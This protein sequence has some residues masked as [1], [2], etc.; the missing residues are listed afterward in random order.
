MNISVHYPITSNKDITNMYKFSNGYY[1]F[2]FS[3]ALRCKT[4][5]LLTDELINIILLD[6]YYPLY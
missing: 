4:F 5:L 1:L 2:L 3:L 6:A